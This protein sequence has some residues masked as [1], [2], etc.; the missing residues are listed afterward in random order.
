MILTILKYGA[1]TVQLNDQ[2]YH[3]IELI[4]LKAL[5]DILRTRSTTINDAVLCETRMLPIKAMFEKEKLQL[6]GNLFS[7]DK[8]RLVRKLFLSSKIVKIDLNEILSNYSLESSWKKYINGKM[9]PLQWKSLV[10]ETIDKIELV[11]IKDSLSKTIKCP[12]LAEINLRILT[13]EQCYDD[14]HQSS[15]VPNYMDLSNNVAEFIFKLKAGSLPLEVETQRYL[16]VPREN[17]ICKICNTGQV[18]DIFHFCFVCPSLKEERDDLMSL[19]E[20]ADEMSHLDLYRSL[21]CSSTNFHNSSLTLHELWKKRNILLFTK[22]PGID[23]HSARS[24]RLHPID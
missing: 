14:N 11:R 13:N 12:E 1:G 9:T 6:F 2:Q 24:S 15:R 8:K 17:R 23:T 18:E 7:L 21:F 4:H 10:N 22:S 5:R 19:F 3:K 16:N 20:R